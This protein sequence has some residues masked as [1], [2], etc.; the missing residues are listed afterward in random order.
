MGFGKNRKMLLILIY[1]L[2]NISRIYFASCVV[3]I[4]CE[5]QLGLVSQAEPVLESGST[6]GIATHKGR[7]RETERERERERKK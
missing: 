2:P 1:S 6:C 5:T 4:Q 3:R 7:E